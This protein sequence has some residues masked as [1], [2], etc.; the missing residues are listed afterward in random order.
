MVAVRGVPPRAGAELLGL[1]N[2][3]HPP[4][5]VVSAFRAD[6]VRLLLLM[7]LGAI[8]HQLRGQEMV[9]PPIPLPGMGVPSFWIGHR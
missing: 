3:H 8:F 6:V 1:S 9:G 2:F 4:P 7:A 5:F